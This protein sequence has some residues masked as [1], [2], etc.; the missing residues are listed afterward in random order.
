MTKQNTFRAVHH[1]Y[2]FQNLQQAKFYSLSHSPPSEPSVRVP[3]CLLCVDVI[4]L[5][6]TTAAVN[7]TDVRCKYL[8]IRFFGY[9]H[10]Y[11]YVYIYRNLYICNDLNYKILSRSSLLWSALPS[12][13]PSYECMV[14]ILH[15]HMYVY[16]ERMH[17]CVKPPWRI[18]GERT[19]P[20]GWKESGAVE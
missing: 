2:T 4:R 18:S 6:A 10:M 1:F 11:M 20:S 16:A 3:A 14:C 5:C 7:T 12:K 13:R 8:C 19:N 17:L 15:I 9:L